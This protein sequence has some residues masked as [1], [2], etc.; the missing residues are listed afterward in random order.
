MKNKK[1]NNVYITETLQKKEIIEAKTKTKTKEKKKQKKYND[2]IELN[3]LDY[4][5]AKFNATEK[6]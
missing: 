6:N 5:S 1:K 3:Y 4:E 2:E